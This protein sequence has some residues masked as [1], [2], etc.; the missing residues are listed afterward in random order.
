M[1]DRD[2]IAEAVEE[3]LH[4]ILTAY[5]D[6]VPAQSI[7]PDVRAGRKVYFG[8]PS[9]SMPGRVELAVM[10]MDKELDKVFDSLRFLAVRVWKS[11]DGG[12]ASTTCFHAT[13]KELRALLEEQLH[14]PDYIVDRIQELANG[15]PEETNPDIW[16]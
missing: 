1:S 16:R 12:T 9:T 3:M 2:D 5:E 13:K 7:F 10:H 8:D 11:R 14:S 4:E 6:R 15:L